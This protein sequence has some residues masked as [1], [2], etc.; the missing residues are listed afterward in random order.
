METKT[1]LEKIKDVLNNRDSICN[2]IF[3]DYLSGYDIINGES[4]EFIFDNLSLRFNINTN[5]KDGE[6]TDDREVICEILL[7]VMITFD[8]HNIYNYSYNDLIIDYTLFKRDA[9]PYFKELRKGINLLLDN[10]I[11]VLDFNKCE[12]CGN[13]CLNFHQEGVIKYCYD[14]FKIEDKQ[15]NCPI[16]LISEEVSNSIKMPCCR[17]DIHI[18]CIKSWLYSKKSCPMCR[19]EYTNHPYLLEV[20]NI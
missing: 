5:H 18:D 14:C 19:N 12:L 13:S 9:F 16:C 8:Q 7:D 4:L 2:S 10:F 17:C 6:C 20:L 15:I 3:N 11:D 1:Q